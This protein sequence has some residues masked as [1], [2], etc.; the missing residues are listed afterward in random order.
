MPTVFRELASHSYYHVG[1]TLYKTF[2]ETYNIY[3]A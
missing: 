2:Q 3:T 1:F